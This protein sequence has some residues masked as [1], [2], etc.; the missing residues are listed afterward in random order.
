MPW[1]QVRV[2]NHREREGVGAFLVQVRDGQRWNERTAGELGGRGG[3]EPQGG[4]LCPRAVPR[5]S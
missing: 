4:K 5:S 1:A 3:W 2:D